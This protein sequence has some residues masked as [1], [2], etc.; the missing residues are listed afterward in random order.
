MKNDAKKASSNFAASDNAAAASGGADTPKTPKRHATPKQKSAL[1]TAA[2]NANEH[3]IAAGYGSSGETRTEEPSPIKP[4][5]AKKSRAPTKPKEG[6]PATKKQKT[7]NVANKA[8]G[9][10]ANVKASF[11]SA[12]TEQLLAASSRDEPGSIKMEEGS[13]G[14]ATTEK[15]RKQGMVDGSNLEEAVEE[16]DEGE[17][18]NQGGQ[19]EEA[20]LAT[21]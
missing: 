6:E 10:K 19:F 9:N 12:F 2:S 4:A 20:M 14:E 8:V 13:D 17:G 11:P 15:K 1:E 7:A 3:D 16:E 5:P 18:G 21:E